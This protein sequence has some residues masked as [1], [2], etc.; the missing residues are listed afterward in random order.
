MNG[1]S[2][3]SKTPNANRY[4]LETPDL[5]MFLMCCYI[6]KDYQTVILFLHFHWNTH[7]LNTLFKFVANSICNYYSI[8]IAF[9]EL[10]NTA[11]MT[12][13]KNNLMLIS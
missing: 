1:F 6:K 11:N 8:T 9:L 13:P 5:K 4:F 12:Q 7:W 2:C 3:I 10:V